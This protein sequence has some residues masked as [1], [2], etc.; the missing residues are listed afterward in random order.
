MTEAISIDL[1]AYRADETHNLTA[2]PDFAKT[3]TYDKWDLSLTFDPPNSM[4]SVKLW[5]KNITD[6]HEVANGSGTPGTPSALPYM[7]DPQSYGVTVS[8]EM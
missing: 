7:Y 4:W 1:Q 6:Q 2:N 8:V 5:G 3:D